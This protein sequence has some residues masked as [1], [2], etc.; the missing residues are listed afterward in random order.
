MN[1][2]PDSYDVIL[3]PK[4]VQA[5]WMDESDTISAPPLLDGGVQV[6][7]CPLP[8]QANTRGH[9]GGH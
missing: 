9:V 5:W 7:I 3:V 1:D 4:R 8:G 6:T 2:L